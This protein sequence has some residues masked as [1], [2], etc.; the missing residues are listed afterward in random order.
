MAFKR[1]PKTASISKLGLDTP[2]RP[3]GVHFG[4]IWGAPRV[5]FRA[6]AGAKNRSKNVLKKHTLCAQKQI[7]S[8][9]LVMTSVDSYVQVVNMKMRD[10]HGMLRRYTF[11]S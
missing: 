5:E 4:P 11:L 1:V 7:G 2:G 9:P 6:P 3:P 8:S 10:E